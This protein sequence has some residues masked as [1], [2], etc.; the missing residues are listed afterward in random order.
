MRQ[1]KS[2]LP[3]MGKDKWSHY[4]LR[5]PIE[6]RDKLEIVCERENISFNALLNFFIREGYE[7]YE[8]Q[9]KEKTQGG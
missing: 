6:L 8:Q 1:D 5:I 9:R 7:R 3:K 2:R 4:L